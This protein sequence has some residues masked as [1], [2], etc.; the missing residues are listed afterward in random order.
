MNRRKY[1]HGQRGK[2]RAKWTISPIKPLYDMDVEIR[3]LR[4][5]DQMIGEV[6]I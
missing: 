1:G 4:I 2:G 3:P 6:R 5:Y